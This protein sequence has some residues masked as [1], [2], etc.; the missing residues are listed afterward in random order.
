MKKRIRII[1]IISII[2]GLMIGL[3]LIIKPEPKTLTNDSGWDSSYDGG[4]DS[5]ESY[6]YDYNRYSK[7]NSSSNTDDAF[8][9]LIVLIVLLLPIL[10][11]R[12]KAINNIKDLKTRLE[13]RG[14]LIEQTFS[15]YRRDEFIQKLYDIF[16]E[17]QI[18]WMNFDYEKLKELC[19]DELYNSYKSDLEVLKSKHCKNI[20]QDFNKIE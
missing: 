18:A 11:S 1:I 8:V 4:D 2:V 19:S 7:N 10:Y 17:V 9:M 12:G 16:L 3:F 20:M 14:Y 13:N 5:Y 6:D 15:E